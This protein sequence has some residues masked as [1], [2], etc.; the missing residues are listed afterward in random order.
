MW[1]EKEREGESE[2][3]RESDRETAFGSHHR[4]PDRLL[5]GD[6]EQD[7]YV[8]SKDSPQITYDLQRE[9]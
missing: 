9:K 4:M 5:Q 1:G 6:K 7:T 3:E 8:A 2:R